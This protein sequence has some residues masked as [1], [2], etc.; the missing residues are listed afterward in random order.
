MKT[1]LVLILSP[2]LLTGC[3]GSAHR[4]ESSGATT[5]NPPKTKNPAVETTP[6][7]S[8]TKEKPELKTGSATP[9]T[10][11]KSPPPMAPMVEVCPVN[12]HFAACTKKGMRFKTVEVNE[13][14]GCL[15]DTHGVVYCHGDGTTGRL[16]TGCHGPK[17]KTDFLT[18]VRFPAGTIITSLSCS[19]LF[20]CAIDT[21][22]DAWCWGGNQEDI[23]AY[24]PQPTPKKY[25]GKSRGGW[26]D[27]FYSWRFSQHYNPQHGMLMMGNSLAPQPLVQPLPRRVLRPAGVA[28]K[29]VTSRF[30]A[31]CAL[32]TAD[33]V[34]CW[35]KANNLYGQRNTLRYLSTPKKTAFADRQRFVS[36]HPNY[37]GGF[38]IDGAGKI[39]V[40]GFG[41]T[42]KKN[43]PDGALQETVIPGKGWVSISTGGS[44]GF[45]LVNN[46]GEEFHLDPESRKSFEQ[47]KKKGT[48]PLD[49]VTVTRAKIPGKS[50]VIKKT[51]DRPTSGVYISWGHRRAGWGRE[52]QVALDK[53][54]KVWLWGPNAYNIPLSNAQRAKVEEQQFRYWWPSAFDP[55]RA[56]IMPPQILPRVKHKSFQAAIVES[57][58]I[59]LLDTDGHLFH[60]REKRQMAR[61]YNSWSRNH[62]RDA[63]CS[64]WRG[65]FQEFPKTQP[66]KRKNISRIDF[67][68]HI[69]KSIPA[70]CRPPKI[71]IPPL[72]LIPIPL[73]GRLRLRSIKKQQHSLCGIG[74]DGALYCFSVDYRSR[75]TIT[76][77]IKLPDGRK[78]ASFQIAQEQVCGVDTQGS[79][80]CFPRHECYRKIRDDSYGRYSRLSCRRRFLKGYKPVVTPM[81]I[82][83]GAKVKSM[84]LER[85]HACLLDDAGRTWCWGDADRNRTGTGLINGDYIPVPTL[86]ALPRGKKFSQIFLG[87]RILLALSDKGTPWC[88]GD[89]CVTSNRYT[90][91]KKYGDYPIATSGERFSRVGYNRN[92]CCALSKK[93]VPWC[94]GQGMGMS[95]FG[96]KFYSPADVGAGCAS[97]TPGK[98]YPLKL[99]RKIRSMVGTCGIDDRGD[100]WCWGTME[101]FKPTRVSLKK[102]TKLDRFGAVAWLPGGSIIPLK[103]P[104][105]PVIPSFFKDSSNSDQFM[106]AMESLRR[107]RRKMRR[108]RR[109]N[110]KPQR[111]PR[112]PRPI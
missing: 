31:T 72:Q 1:L 77:P 78:W 20:C 68:K 42:G 25:S 24:T 100:T 86:F 9:A 104:E 95:S 48:L 46:K 103:R 64:I 12:D 84:F 66:W 58:G 13:E 112:R 41:K 30:G 76:A 57:P 63:T 88:L 56:L 62:Y 15:L 8:T 4:G 82:P 38:G 5:V 108:N 10:A 97:L 51:W 80:W 16:G 34:W 3:F 69:S 99:P 73:P 70:I 83:A 90:T 26:G 55:R 79:A 43:L 53:D 52:T 87:D 67:L 21:P 49:P 18:P 94:W 23:N 59:L 111:A 14:G 54:G 6:K 92:L 71:I 110:N 39:W 11:K 44:W 89:G 50:V 45:F 17:C 93:G 28:F 33:R 91:H 107:F 74:H 32:D 37:E 98:A 109:R 106:K 7:S 40:W 19:P 101:G 29:E 35:G 36:I 2:V 60:L 81:A 65:R 47:L 61:R 22:G 75:I 102:A 96:V 85:Q 27:P 105:M